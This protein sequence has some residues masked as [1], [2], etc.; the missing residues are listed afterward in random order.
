M[1]HASVPG[2][3]IHTAFF[4]DGEN[5][6]IGF[7]RNQES[8]HPNHGAAYKGIF[9]ISRHGKADILPAPGYGKGDGIPRFQ[10]HHGF[11]GRGDKYFLLPDF[12]RSF[13]ISGKAVFKETISAPGGNSVLRR[14]PRNHLPL[15]VGFHAVCLIFRKDQPLNL[16]GLYPFLS[17][18]AFQQE[19]HIRHIGCPC[20]KV[21]EPRPLHLLPDVA[22]SYKSNH[23]H[24]CQRKRRQKHKDC[25]SKKTS[26]MPFHSCPDYHLIFQHFRLL[27]PT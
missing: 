12:F 18:D 26:F 24:R 4:Y 3:S 27:L 6:F 5:L 16:C 17:P 9:I 2:Q 15:T 21:S 14:Y 23:Q 1:N 22:V 19:F 7:F 25:D 20:G 10:I 13:C 11:H 8:L